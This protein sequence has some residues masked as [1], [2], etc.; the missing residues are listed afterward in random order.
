MQIFK[1]K[2]LGTLWNCF[3]MKAKKDYYAKKKCAITILYYNL[4]LQLIPVI[5]QLCYPVV[6]LMMWSLSQGRLFAGSDLVILGSIL[7]NES[8]HIF[9]TFTYGKCG[10]FNFGNE[11]VDN[12]DMLI[13][14]FLQLYIYMEQISFKSSYCWFQELICNFDLLH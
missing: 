8:I 9:T 11:S 7:R 14:L 13:F 10:Y 3:R 12:E 2:I 5:K 1:L 6:M 4:F